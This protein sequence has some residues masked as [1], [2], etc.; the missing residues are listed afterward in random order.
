MRKALKKATSPINYEVDIE[1]EEE[2]NLFEED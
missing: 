2:D 1:D